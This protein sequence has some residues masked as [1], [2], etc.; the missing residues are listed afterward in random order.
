MTITINRESGT[1][2]VVAFIKANVPEITSNIFIV[3]RWVWANFENKPTAAIWDFLKV[4]GFRY[5]GKRKV[6]QHCC[7]APSRRA[8][9]DPRTK[10]KVR[11]VE[12]LE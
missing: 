8:P 5:N 9:Y 1:N 10:Y 7:N 11:Q 3:G 12:D 4:S 2:E 6:W